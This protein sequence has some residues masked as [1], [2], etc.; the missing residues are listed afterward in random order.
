MQ[1]AASFLGSYDLTWQVVGKDANGGPVVEFH[2][3]NASTL[4]SAKL[5]KGKVADYGID[6]SAGDGHDARPGE[7]W[8]QQSVRWREPFTTDNQPTE[9]V[10]TRD[11]VPWG[12]PNK[13]DPFGQAAI[14]AALKVAKNFL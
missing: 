1:E 5:D 6:L 2:L 11:G 10:G 14:Y 4:N 8:L 13:R 3:T 7:H 12:D 9:H